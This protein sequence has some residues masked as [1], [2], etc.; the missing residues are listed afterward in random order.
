[1]FY[2]GCI[3]FAHGEC[4]LAVAQNNSDLIKRMA[5]ERQ[6]LPFGVVPYVIEISYVV[7][8][9]HSCDHCCSPIP[10]NAVCELSP[11]GAAGEILHDV[12]VTI[13]DGW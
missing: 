2:G 9:R 8:A 4:P 3:L 12:L 6:F 5:Q 13:L 11:V 10:R 7:H 1:M